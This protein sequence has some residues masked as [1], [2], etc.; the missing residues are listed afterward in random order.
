MLVKVVSSLVLGVI[1]GNV[2]PYWSEKGG[3]LSLGLNLNGQPPVRQWAFGSPQQLL[4]LC[5][6]RYVYGKPQCIFCWCRN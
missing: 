6:V 4:V 5:I 2:R 1:L 3:R